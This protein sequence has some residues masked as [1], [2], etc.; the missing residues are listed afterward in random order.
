MN[1]TISLPLRAFLLASL[2]LLQACSGT[3]DSPEAQVRAFV[4]AGVEACVARSA[5]D[6]RELL[7]RDYADQR[8]NNA[9]QLTKLLRAYFFRHKNIHL[10]SRIDTI[11]ILDD[12]R[13]SVTLHVAMAGTVIS[14]VEALAGLRAEVYRFELQLERE[15]TWQL[16]HAS[17][18]P[19]SLAVFE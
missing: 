10:F 15:E 9:E 3:E 12:N 7:H 2:L 11:E 14:D 17:W 16:R 5:G 8:G 4:D 19:A 1:M 13:A 18:S 6:I